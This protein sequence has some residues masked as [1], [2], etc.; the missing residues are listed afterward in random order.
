ML[1]PA[2]HPPQGLNLDNL[3]A[4][5]RFAFVDGLSRLFLPGP[6]SAP[7]TTT[8]TGAAAFYHLDSPHLAAVART[9]GA[10]VDRLRG[11]GDADADVVLVLDQPDAL[12][13]AAGPGDG[14]TS[15]GLR[16]VVLD[17]REVSPPTP[18]F[19]LFFI[20]PFWLACLSLAFLFAFHAVLLREWGWSRAGGP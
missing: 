16:E 4:T 15:V 11:A 20:L 7:T 3:A 8:T 12:L 9:L 13:A 5:G 18:L 19:L 10:A 14:V 2:T 1:T 6:S 17:L